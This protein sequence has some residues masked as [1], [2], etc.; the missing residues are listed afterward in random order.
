MYRYSPPKSNIWGHSLRKMEPARQRAL[1]DEFLKQAVAE[2]SFVGGSLTFF[3]GA[4]PAFFPSE[5]QGMWGHVTSNDVQRF[6]QLLGVAARQGS[7]HSLTP[8]QCE[9]ALNEII[10]NSKLIPGSM[11]LQRVE[12]SKWLIEG[13]PV[14]TQSWMVLYYGMKPC[15]STFLQFET[16]GQFEFIKRVLS[17]LDFCKLIEKHLKPIKRGLK[18]KSGEEADE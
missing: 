15:I 6:E 9:A 18:K 1:F 10:Q 17:D 5:S 13:Q 16:T 12:I 11:L 8:E 7:F 14:A 2:H 3:T 4:A